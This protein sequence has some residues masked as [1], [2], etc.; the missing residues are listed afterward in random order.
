MPALRC[1]E[2]APAGLVMGP[3]SEVLGTRGFWYD[4]E[5]HKPS[6]ESACLSASGYPR[7]HR[8]PRV[9]AG[10][11]VL[12]PG[13]VETAHKLRVEGM[14]GVEHGKAQ[15]VGGVLYDT[16]QMQDGEVLGP[17]RGV[18]P[19]TGLEQGGM[20]GGSWEGHRSGYAPWW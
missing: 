5:I 17:R 7:A 11:T 15:D 4:Q 6:P 18:R 8:R 9:G 12:S 1:G 16:V 14:G 3:H 10:F 19:E 2:E 13:H 20:A